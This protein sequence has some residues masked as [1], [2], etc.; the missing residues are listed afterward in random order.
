MILTSNRASDELLVIVAG[1]RAICRGW[2][3]I[4]VIMS[5]RRILAACLGAQEDS[6][7][8]EEVHGLRAYGAIT[9]HI[10][11]VKF[12]HLRR[13]IASRLLCQVSR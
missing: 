2:E 11:G 10:R 13:S 3:E 8:A 5:T 9:R 6:S 7:T 12:I 4:I 1:E